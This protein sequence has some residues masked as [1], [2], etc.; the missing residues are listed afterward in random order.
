MSEPTRTLTAQC[1]CKAVHFSITVPVSSLPL[2][3]HLCQCFI[4][5][6][7]HG[8]FACFHAPL[9]V[10]I[11]PVFIAP[12][13]L[14]GTTTGYT[15][16]TLAAATRYFCSTCG[17]HIGDRDL[18]PVPDSSGQEPF[19]EWR[20]TTSIFPAEAQSTAFLIT[21]HFYA[22]AEPGPTLATWLPRLEFSSSPPK[23]IKP[24]TPAPN[25]PT[26]PIPR[27]PLPVPE[28]H[29]DGHPRLRAECHCGGVSFTICRPD[30]PV[31]IPFGD[32]VSRFASKTD[33]KK[34]LA[35]LDACDD[36]RLVTGA[37]VIGW[38][39]VPS[40]AI[41]PRPVLPS[42]EGFGTMRTY[43]SSEGVTRG[44]C[45]VCGATAVYFCEA[46]DRVV[47]EGEGREWIVDV[48]VGLLRDPAGPAAEGW[49][50]L[51]EWGVQKDGE[52]L[53]FEI[54]DDG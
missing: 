10:P 53:D 46:A 33:D 12:S 50:G 7:V 1:H 42:F 22:H 51:R 38:T 4:C 32:L 40:R 29:R 49:G 30:H 25:D 16:S 24:I 41:E 45:G 31:L 28:R 3:T 6:R 8:T 39:F 19:R 26:F 5:R 47:G 17:C 37:H 15:H 23:E 9:P 21:T 34:W 54:P 18:D 36:C 13:S 52:A 14:Q 43:S 35:T 11:E 44:F 48:A 20:I 2:R 27:P